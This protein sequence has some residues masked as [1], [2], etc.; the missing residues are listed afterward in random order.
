MPLQQLAVLSHTATDP[1]APETKTARLE[2]APHHLD[3]FGFGE[4]G[5]LFDLVEGGSIFPAH[6]HHR[7]DLLVAKIFNFLTHLIVGVFSLTMPAL[8]SGNA[9]SNK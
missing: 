6:A 3:H 4:T 8:L 1:L 7:V 2:L 9:V 5:A